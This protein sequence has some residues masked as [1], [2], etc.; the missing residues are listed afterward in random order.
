MK[1]ILSKVLATAMLGMACYAAEVQFRYTLLVNDISVADSSFVFGRATD[2]SDGI[3]DLDIPAIPVFDGGGLG[4]APVEDFYFRAQASSDSN[5]DASNAFSKLYTDIRS[6]SK[7]ANTWTLCTNSN[8]VVLS[9]KGQYYDNGTTINSALADNA[10]TLALYDANDNVLVAD[11]RKTN[12]YTLA[13]NSV[14]NI[15]Y[16]AKDASTPAP[17]TPEEISRN[18]VIW[19]GSVAEIRILEPAKYSLVN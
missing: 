2:A 19:N 17:E 8:S 4:A 6:T 11:M 18:F 3:D 1:N 13:A 16:I 14:Y 7:N 10:G 12:A 5:N 9:W 15:K